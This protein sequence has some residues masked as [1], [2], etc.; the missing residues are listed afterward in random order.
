MFQSNDRDLTA[1]PFVNA[2]INVRLPLISKFPLSY[3]CTCI[4]IK[5]IN[6]GYFTLIVSLISCYCKCYMT[7]PHG[8]VGWS[9]V[10]DCGIC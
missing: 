5:H 9:A 8:V 4:G 3:K 1:M 10:R 7:L 2:G 6:A